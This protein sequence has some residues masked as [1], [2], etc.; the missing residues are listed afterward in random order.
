MSKIIVMEARGPE[1]KSP[2]SIKKPGMATHVP[3][4]VRWWGRDWQIQELITSIV[5]H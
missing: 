2:A 5:K 3:T 4:M 1:F